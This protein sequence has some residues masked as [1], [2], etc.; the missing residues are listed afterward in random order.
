MKRS[1]NESLR[2]ELQGPDGDWS[3]V[4]TLFNSSDVNWFTFEDSYWSDPD[5][6]VLGQVFEEKGRAGTYRKTNVSLPGWFSHLLPEG[7]LRTQVAGKLG[8]PEVREFPMLRGLG[9]TDLP[10]AVRVL[11]DRRVESAEPGEW[12]DRL[13]DSDSMPPELKFSLAGVQMKYSVLGTGAGLT[14]PARDAAGDY[15]LKLPDLR[16]GFARVPESEHA[17]MELGRAVGLNV[18]SSDLVSISDVDGL[19]AE[20]DGTDTALL[21]PR[22]DR[23]GPSRRIHVE[24]FGQIMDISSGRPREKYE[25]SNFEG[26][27]RIASA[28]A[29]SKRDSK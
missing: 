24:H 17:V 20:L 11:P 14:V 29:V 8:I 10:G 25:K 6:H 12:E 4:G 2:V 1:S 19:P 28:L 21:I 15:I 18:V 7:F 13:Q 27:G 3:R 26:I 9:A 22:F 5:R 23:S 16:P